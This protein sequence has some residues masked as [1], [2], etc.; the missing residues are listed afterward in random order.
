[1]QFEEDAAWG[2]NKFIPHI[3]V[4]SRCAEF[5]YLFF[6]VIYRDDAREI[7]SEL[8]FKIHLVSF[9]HAFDIN[10]YYVD[11]IDRLDMRTFYCERFY[12]I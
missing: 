5:K 2:V 3:F 11:R 7:G 4:I 8:T 1:M 10:T 6:N 12:I 9:R